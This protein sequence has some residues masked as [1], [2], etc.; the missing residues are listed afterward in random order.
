MSEKLENFIKSNKKHFDDLE[1]PGSVWSRIESSL[2]EQNKPRALKRVKLWNLGWIKVAATIAIC[3][4]AALLFWQQ[5][6]SAV[7]DISRINP[8]LAKQQYYYTSVIQEK[9]EELKQ[10]RK[11]DPA[12][13]EEFSTEI[14]AIEENYKKL[15]K[16]L[17]HSPNREE[18]VKAMIKNLQIQIEILNEQL[19]V[20]DRVNQIKKEYKNETKSI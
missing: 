11:E 16:G 14:N 18:T 7:A 8:Q 12:L 9:Q 3:V 20:I 1:V 10:I 19:E 15:K 4:T 2:D 17:S 6:K 13:Y 5:Q